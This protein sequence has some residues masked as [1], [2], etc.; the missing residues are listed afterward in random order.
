MLPV[1]WGE[2]KKTALQSRIVN[3][4][5]GV[6]R[7]YA[8]KIFDS[9]ARE[10]V[11]WEGNTCWTIKTGR[12]NAVKR[13]EIT[14]NRRCQTCEKKDVDCLFVKYVSGVVTKGEGRFDGEKFVKIKG[15]EEVETVHGKR[16][17]LHC[18]G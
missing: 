5:K 14:A 4:Y 16:W 8:E 3:S 13:G 1:N 9:L 2:E 10:F 17:E 18:R 12:I 7:G 15:G 11:E 6:K